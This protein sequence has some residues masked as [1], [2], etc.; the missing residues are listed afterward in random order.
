M[1]KYNTNEQIA[2]LIAKYDALEE[3]TFDGTHLDSITLSAKQ[4][5]GLFDNVS[6]YEKAEQAFWEDLEEIEE[7]NAQ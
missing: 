2:A 7:F 1:K 6:D 5:S 4:Q 3:N